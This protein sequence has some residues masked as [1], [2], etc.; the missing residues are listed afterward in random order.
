MTRS[1][2]NRLFISLLLLRV[3]DSTKKM[4]QFS[5]SWSKPAAS[6]R[7]VMGPIL[8]GRYKSIVPPGG[9]LA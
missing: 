4:A 2:V 7:T 1:F 5:G 6:D 8:C 3:A 9:S